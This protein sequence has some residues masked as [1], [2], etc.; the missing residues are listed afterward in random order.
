MAGSEITN[1]L[2]RTGITLQDI[3]LDGNHI[4]ERCV[5]ENATQ[6]DLGDV[7]LEKYDPALVNAVWIAGCAYSHTPLEVQ[8]HI[9]L[10]TFLATCIDDFAI[11]HAALDAFM[12][13]FYSGSLQLHPLLDRLVENLLDMKNYFPTFPTKLIIKSTIDFINMMAFEQEMDVTTLRPAAVSYV[14][15]KRFYNGAG[16]AYFCFIFDKFNFPDASGYIQALP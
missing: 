10:Y 13:R 2:R 6:L 12:E 9:A 4:L 14:T 1:F 15:M 16:D 8:V 7:S 11:P 5:R 3:T